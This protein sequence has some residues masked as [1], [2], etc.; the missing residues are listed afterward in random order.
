[1]TDTLVAVPVDTAT[2]LSGT[3]LVESASALTSA[4]ASG[5]WVEG[6]LS[7]VGVA[8]DIA[9]TVLDPLGSLFGAGLGWLLDHLEP[10]KGWFADFTGDA[11][12]VAAFGRTWGNIRA[13]LETAG[14]DLP[15]LV[16]QLD[17]LSGE[18]IEAYR[19]FQDETAA[20]LLAAASWAGAMASGLQIASGVVQAVHELVRDVL[21]QLVGSIISWALEAAFSIGLATPLIIGQVT[22]KVA[23]WSAKVGRTV[24]EALRSCRALT[25]LLDELR[26]LMS[27]AGALFD[28]VLRGPRGSAGEVVL[29]PTA[30]RREPP[31]DRRRD[32]SAWVDVATPEQIARD[33]EALRGYTGPDHAE[34]NAALR[35]E[36]P[37]TPELREKIDAAV[38]ALDRLPDYVGTVFRGEYA[39]PGALYLEAYQPGEV[40]TNPAFTST[41]RFEPFPGNV[42]YEI[43]SLHG[44]DVEH[45]S[46]FS[47][48]E[49]E[50]LFRPGTQFLVIAREDEVGR[51][52]IA[53]REVE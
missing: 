50:V 22:A 10:L 2:P 6:T 15:R 20:H 51:T 38:R 43:Q 11:G 30:P 16:G 36:I 53:M 46:A 37:M 45:L 28:G 13:Q 52:L 31:P 8:L 32:S 29:F 47:G 25:A 21:S 24:L 44:K 4:I 27:R 5:D 14:R 40:V 23:S 42:L 33:L 35:G 17:E 48:D 26:A 18:T 41:D 12:Q 49:A 7:G 1:V 34:M 39:P 9:S 3:G 19:R